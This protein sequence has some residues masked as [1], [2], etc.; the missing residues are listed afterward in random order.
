M[1]LKAVASKVK[2][3]Q[4]DEAEKEIQVGSVIPLKCK[5]KFLGY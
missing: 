3:G 2:A 4:Y 5:T 1:S